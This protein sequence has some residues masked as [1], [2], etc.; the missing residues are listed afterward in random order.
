MIFSKIKVNMYTTTEESL[1]ENND[2]INNLY[3]IFNVDEIH[4]IHIECGV[5]GIVISIFLLSCQV[6]ITRIDKY[7]IYRVK[8]Q[9]I[10]TILHMLFYIA[11]CSLIFKINFH[12]RYKFFFWFVNLVVVFIVDSAYFIFLA[13]DICVTKI[14]GYRKSRI[15]SKEVRIKIIS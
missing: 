9:C 4:A 15:R 3:K 5:I 1:V 10:L 8:M 2:I 11:S 14:Q 7:F 13:F 6:V 12:P